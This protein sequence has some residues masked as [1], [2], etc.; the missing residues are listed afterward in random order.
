MSY[1][2]TCRV[3][4]TCRS[5]GSAP[6]DRRSGLA[7]RV[8]VEP[9]PIGERASALGVDWPAAVEIPIGQDWAPGWYEV[10]LTTSTDGEPH[11]P[12]MRG[13]PFVRRPVAR[14][15]RCCSCS[16]PTR[17]TRTTIG[18]DRTCTPARRRFRSPA[19]G[20]RATCTARTRS[21]IATRTGADP[22]S[23]DRALD[24]LHPRHA[25]VALVGLRRVAELGAD[26]RGLGRAQRVRAR[27]RGQR[28]SRRTTRRGR[29]APAAAER[30]ARR[31]LVVGHARHRR[32]AHRRRRER[33]L[34]LRQHGVLAGSARRTTDRRWCA[35][36]CSTTRCRATRPRPH[37][38]S[39][40]SDPRI[41]RPESQ[42][43]GVSF[44]RGGYA[45]I[46]QGVPR[47]AGGYTIW[48][49]ST[50]SLLTPICGM[51]TC[52]APNTPSSATS[53]TVAR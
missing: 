6:T 9:H 24:A 34:P 36:S 7:V 19:P 53:A 46:G 12:H 40:W 3:T 47:G 29:W 37:R 33:R 18:A 38:T 41:G 26:V 13:S 20:R 21:R 11:V 43:T 4:S 35:T 25:C 2:A 1:R 5:A 45:R 22:G 8:R 27:L 16:R 51:A 50:G 14:V 17:G 48:Q 30:R 44:T 52:S 31:V 49:P 42:M 32:R 10:E 23:E 39:M 28:R 15:R